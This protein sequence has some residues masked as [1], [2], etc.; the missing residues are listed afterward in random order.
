MGFT[1]VI[2]P[3]TQ[4]PSFQRQRSCRHG[5]TIEKD[6]HLLYFLALS[7]VLL[8]DP[9]ADG[10][11][12]TLVLCHSK[13]SNHAGARHHCRCVFPTYCSVRRRRCIAGALAYT[14]RPQ[15]SR[16]VKSR[17]WLFCTATVP[18]LTADLRK[19]SVRQHN[20][21]ETLPQQPTV[22]CHCVFSIQG[23]RSGLAFLKFWTRCAK[24]SAEDDVEQRAFVGV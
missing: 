7:Q 14:A 9:Q 20:N 15:L 23:S 2:M 19:S 18:Q 17:R 21:P 16:D 1:Y 24:S 3:Y 5:K 10:H 6:M 13:S 4:S 12:A 8:P 11:C 22:V